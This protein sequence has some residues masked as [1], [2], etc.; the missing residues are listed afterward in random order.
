VAAR[1]ISNVIGAR[2]RPLFKI[3]LFMVAFPAVS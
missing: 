2:S 3:A 1:P